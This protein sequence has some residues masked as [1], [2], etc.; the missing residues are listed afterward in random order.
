MSTELNNIQRI[1][2]DVD[3]FSGKAI[4]SGSHTRP[5]FTKF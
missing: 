4:N 2:H 5:K 1:V 3:L